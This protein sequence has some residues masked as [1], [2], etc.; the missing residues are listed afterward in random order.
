MAKGEVG[1][2]AAA[3]DRH[4]LLPTKKNWQPTIFPLVSY[5]QE[6]AKT[7]TVVFLSFTVSPVR[8]PCDK[9][10]FEDR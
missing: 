3:A 7:P 6:V 10:I 2:D 1:G 5:Y 9:F 8:L 4:G